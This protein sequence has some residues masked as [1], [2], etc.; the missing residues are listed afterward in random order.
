MD[1]NKL[2]LLFGFIGS[3]TGVIAVITYFEGK[4]KRALTE[5]IAGLDKQI[6]LL[7]LQEKTANNITF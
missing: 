2:V 5:D 4:K 3:L 6:K 7:T 1:K